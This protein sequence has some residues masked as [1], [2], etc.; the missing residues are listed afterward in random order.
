MMLLE[1]AY[2]AW[3]SVDEYIRLSM[4]VEKKRYL[5]IWDDLSRKELPISCFMKAGVFVDRRP[6]LHRMRKRPATIIA[7]INQ[8]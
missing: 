3:A 5:I 7:L 8:T 2:N 6:V 4:L 1:H